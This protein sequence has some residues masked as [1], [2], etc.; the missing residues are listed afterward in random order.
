MMGAAA[1][2]KQLVTGIKIKLRR[3]HSQ[4][5]PEFNMYSKLNGKGF[6]SNIGLDWKN[7]EFE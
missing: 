4:T 1:F 6:L 5:F 3:Y 7:S 2:S